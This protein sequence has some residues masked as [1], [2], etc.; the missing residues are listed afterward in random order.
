ML[1]GEFDAGAAIFNRQLEVEG[2]LRA[3]SQLTGMLSDG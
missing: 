2:D 1:S 3:L